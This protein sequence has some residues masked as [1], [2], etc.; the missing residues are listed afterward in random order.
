M[1]SYA[2]GNAVGANPMSVILGG[3][4]KEKLTLSGTRPP[5]LWWGFRADKERIIYLSL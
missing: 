4:S 1:R 5:Q 3:G 2:P